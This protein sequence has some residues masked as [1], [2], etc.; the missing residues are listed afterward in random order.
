MLPKAIVKNPKQAIK[1]IK[2]LIQDWYK[3]HF[4]GVY[5]YLIAG[6][7]PGARWQALQKANAHCATAHYS[8]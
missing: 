4:F 8:C 7:M 1:A 6:I 2:P 3:E 5:L